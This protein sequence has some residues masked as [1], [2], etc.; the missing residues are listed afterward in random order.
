MKTKEDLIID[1]LEYIGDR[2]RGI[3]QALDKIAERMP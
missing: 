2:L 1:Q 3:E